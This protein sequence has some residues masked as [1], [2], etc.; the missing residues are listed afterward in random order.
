MMRNVRGVESNKAREDLART[1]FI[2]TYNQPIGGDMQR[3][4][5][6]TRGMRGAEDEDERAAR[7]SHCSFTV[8]FDND[9]DF[10]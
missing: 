2:S 7:A 3:R 8:D 5:E 6:D 1:S 10:P 4:D 9:V